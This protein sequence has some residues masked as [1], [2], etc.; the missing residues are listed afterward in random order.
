MVALEEAILVIQGEYMYRL[1]ERVDRTSSRRN[2]LP[3]PCQ[4]S[5]L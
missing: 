4:E 5:V 3:C 2:S 1:G